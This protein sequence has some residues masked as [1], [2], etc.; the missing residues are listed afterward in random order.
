[1]WVSWIYI[2]DWINESNKKRRQN[3]KLDIKNK[4]GRKT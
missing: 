4:T 1:M 2:R 3:I